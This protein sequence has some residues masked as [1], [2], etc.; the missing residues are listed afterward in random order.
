VEHLIDL[1]KEQRAS[2]ARPHY[3]YSVAARLFFGAMDVLAGPENTLA[4]VRLLEALAPIPYRAWENHQH[5]RMALNYDDKELVERGNALVRW[6]R[7]AQDNEYWHLLVVHEKMREG[8]GREPRYMVRPLPYL[9]VASYALMM[10][11]MARVALRRSLL[12]NAEFEDHS[13]HVYAELVDQHPEWETQPVT[14][15]LVQQYGSF[16][17]WADVFRRIGLDERDHMNNSFVF[18][19]RLDRVVPYE[20]MPER[21]STEPLAA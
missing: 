15:G 12:L 2:R 13:E 16:D 20:G 1:A 9:M 10:G 3:R 4:K 21:E 5:A 17:S 18:A 19:G 14:S 7:E 11:T 6:G 8:S